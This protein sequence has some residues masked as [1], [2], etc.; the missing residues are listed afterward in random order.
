M[1]QTAVCVCVRSLASHQGDWT[2]GVYQRERSPLKGKL[3]GRRRGGGGGGVRECRGSKRF[4][5]TMRKSGKEGEK[6][7]EGADKRAIF[8]PPN[9]PISG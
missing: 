6:E 9:C 5:E 3:F 8:S 4:G 2:K 1:I 7:R